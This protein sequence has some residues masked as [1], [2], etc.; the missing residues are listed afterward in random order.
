MRTRFVYAG[1]AALGMVAACNQSTAPATSGQVKMAFSTRPAPTAAGSAGVTSSIVLGSDTM[2]T[3]TDTLVIDTVQ[4]VLRKIELKRVEG[5]PCDTVVSHEGD[6]GCEEVE[7]GPVLLNLPV[8]DTAATTFSVSIPVGSYDKVEFQ[9]HVPTSDARDQAFLAANP[10]FTGSSIRVVGSFNGKAFTFTSAL[11][12]EQE[13][14]LSPVL[15]VADTAAVALTIRTDVSKWFANGTA[16]IDPS[17]ALAGQ[18]NEALV[19]ENIRASFRGFH[20][21]D[22]DGLDDNG[23][24]TH[25]GS[26]G[27]GGH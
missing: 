17:T 11:T 15:T 18:P 24:D 22:E 13:L 5:S 19:Q 16:L 4:I 26:G 12:A 7:A 8:G 20:D 21:Q 14:E 10:L 1:L 9:V 23:E 2:S 27:T 3:A 6:D 25:D